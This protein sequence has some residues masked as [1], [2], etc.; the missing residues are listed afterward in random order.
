MVCSM[1]EMVL[2]GAWVSECA[3]DLHIQVQ[4][5][6]VLLIESKL[7]CLLH[8]RPITQEKACWDKEYGLYLENQ[9]EK[10]DSCPKEPCV[11]GLDASSFSRTNRER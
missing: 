1:V 11:Q 8:S 3:Q 5:I 10:I 9:T 7:Y 2:A 4:S 6:Q